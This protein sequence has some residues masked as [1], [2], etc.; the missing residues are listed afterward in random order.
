MTK[1]EARRRSRQTEVLQHARA[2][3]SDGFEQLTMAALA[4]KMDASV[5]GLYR[6]YASKEAIL[7]APSKSSFSQAK[8]GY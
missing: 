1:R 4:K 8:S 2:L 7:T 3:I 6:Y 5:G